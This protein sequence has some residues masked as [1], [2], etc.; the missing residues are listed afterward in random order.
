M[1][2]FIYCDL[3]SYI[4]HISLKDTPSINSSLDAAELLFENWNK[5]T[6]SLC[7]NFKELLL[8]NSNKVKGVYELSK[9]GVTGTLVDMHILFAIVLKSLSAG[10]ILAH[11]MKN[12]VM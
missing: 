3:D 11:Y 7:E 6:I 2:S 4:E 1:N 12:V 10:I 8:N 5:N 9:G